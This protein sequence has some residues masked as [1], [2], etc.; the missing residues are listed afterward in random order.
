[1]LFR[2]HVLNECCKQCRFARDMYLLS[3]VTQHTRF[4]VSIK[5]WNAKQGSDTKSDTNTSCITSL[6]YSS[7]VFLQHLFVSDWSSTSCRIKIV[8]HSLGHRRETRSSIPKRRS[9]ELAKP[10]QKQNEAKESSIQHTWAGAVLGTRINGSAA[11]P[12]VGSQRSV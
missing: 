12:M 9:T 8:P 2:I 6:A 3:M 10:D 7:V 5:H 11:S 1:M 4:A